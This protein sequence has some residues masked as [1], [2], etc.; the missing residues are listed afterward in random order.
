MA[1]PARMNHLLRRVSILSVCLSAAC[2]SSPHA[3]AP[4]SRPERW[5]LSYDGTYGR[6]A[7]DE[8]FY[9][10]AFAGARGAECARGLFTG[11]IFLG[12]QNA[13]AGRW[14]APWANRN[15]PTLDTT[16]EDWFTYLDTLASPSGPLERLDKA[17]KKAGGR[18]VDVAVMVPA[19]MSERSALPRI[20][21]R[22]VDV[23]TESG[24]AIYASYLDSL[25]SKFKR[26]GFTHLRLRAAYWLRE[27][28][29][30]D[31][32]L[33]ARQVAAVVHERGFQ[34]FWVPYFGAGGVADWRSLGFD[35]AWLQPNYFLRQELAHSRLDSAL[36][37]AKSHGLG[38]EV[39]FD[40]RIFS[41]PASV[42]RL[43]EYLDAVTEDRTLST[44]LYDGGGALVKLFSDTTKALAPLRRQL[45]AALCR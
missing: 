9:V 25:N 13:Q 30:G 11:V 12:V 6:S 7:S 40:G 4:R 1:K 2:A 23:G 32:A 42:A 31:E 21:T 10:R 19:L 3:N 27:S 34:F 41:G 35:A 33:I 28:A 14:F 45:T 43:T 8:N 37:V 16:L 38:L 22:R 44:A 18:T 17:T 29:W 36:A 24:R 5:L 39:E 15:S 26:G 20:S